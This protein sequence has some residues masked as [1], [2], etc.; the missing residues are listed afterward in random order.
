MPFTLI[1][2]FIWS[3]LSI[4]SAALPSDFNISDII[5]VLPD[6]IALIYNDSLISAATRVSNIKIY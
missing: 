1:S 5:E 2:H 3:S 6:L 4:P